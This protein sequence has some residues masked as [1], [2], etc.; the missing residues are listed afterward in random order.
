MQERTYNP[1]RPADEF[2]GV[3]ATQLPG[4]PYGPD[5]KRASLNHRTHTQKTMTILATSSVTTPQIWMREHV[6]STM[7][8]LSCP[9]IRTVP[10]TLACQPC[11]WEPHITDESPT[12][13]FSEDIGIFQ[14]PSFSSA[15]SWTAGQTEVD[16]PN[17][18]QDQLS[19]DTFSGG[20]VAP[21]S[22]SLRPLYS[23]PVYPPRTSLQPRRLRLS[24]NF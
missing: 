1:E 4:R 15:G 13:S 14:Q 9:T 7:E 17:T 23:V 2:P 22:C 6:S 24:T 8:P 11:P 21:N 5:R 10:S 3:Y 20:T 16:N 12:P 19:Q 18:G